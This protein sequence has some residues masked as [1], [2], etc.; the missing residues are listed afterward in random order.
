MEHMVFLSHSSADKLIAQAICSHLESAGIRCWIAP[1]DID[2]TDWA[3]AIMSGL[4]RCDVF[5]VIVS[6]NSINSPEVT[7]EITEA[8][9]TCQY[10]LP[11]KVDSDELNDRMRYHLGPCHWLDA[12]T[13][14]IER[15]IQELEQR[16]RHLSEGDAVYQNQHRRKLVERIVWPRS[17]FVGRDAEIAEIAE[18]LE[19][20]HVLFLQGMGGIGKSEIAKAYAKTYRDRYDTIIFAGYTGSILD[21]VN[22]DAIPIENLTRGS[23]DT[24]SNEAF[25]ARKLEILKSLSSER[26]L[27]IIDNFDT[28]GD[29]DLDSLLSGPYHVLITTRNEHED[30]PVLKIGKIRDF[31]L[32]RHIFTSNYGKKLTPEDAAVVDDIL[33][34]VGCHTI[35]VELIAK[36]MKASRRKPAQ[37]LQMLQSTGTNTHLKEKIK[38]SSTDTGLSA[39][40]YIRQMFQLSGLGEKERH[41]LCCMCMLPYTGIDISTFS[42][43]C[44][45]DSYDDI[46]SLLAKSWLMLDEDTDILSL[47]PVICDVIKAELEPSPLSCKDYILG[48]WNYAK[49]CWYFTVEERSAIIPYV[50][51]IQNNYPQP[52]REL[53][54]QYGDFVNIAWMCYDFPRSQR[55][56]HI[57]YDF[58]LK[59]FGPGSREAGLAA[60]W[61]AGAYHNGGNNDDAEPYYR[62]G[63]E[64]LLESLGPDHYQV[65]NGYGKLGRCA[66]FKHDFES[67]KK[68]LDEGLAVFQRAAAKETDPA[69]R[70]MINY[71]SGDLIV[72]FERLYMEMGDYETALQYCRQSYDTFLLKDGKQT[73][74]S[75]YSLVDMGICYSKLGRFAEAEEYL[76]RALEVNITFNGQASVQTVRTRE[77]IADNAL[78]K[79]DIEAAR[80]LYLQLELDLEQDFG[81]KNPQ[82]RQLREKREAIEIPSH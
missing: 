72:E 46:N 26:T 38:H 58:S 74:N 80:K 52:V 4:R 59:E 14:P 13:P 23:A 67:S 42:D 7:K 25:F 76:N 37:M 19:N 8:T 11:F 71:R 36:Q 75:A 16:I 5:V 39:F 49:N 9:H 69:E 3:S 24:E 12:V 20:E 81:P 51:Y 15:R 30:Y 45:L 63:L 50:A 17:L 60:T 56:G 29:P 77:A 54:L 34:L 33:R 44:G 41:L 68:Y 78:A 66:Y 53:W 73:P 21:L 82:V 6:H 28:D 40:D 65:G 10:I 2:S 62:L 48:L 18:M 22:S 27:L 47:H 55:S 32:V 1:R 35:T 61:L 31:D 64:H 70:N 57:F 79:G 43:W